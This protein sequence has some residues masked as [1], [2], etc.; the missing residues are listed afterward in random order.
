M[1]RPKPTLYGGQVKLQISLEV[2]LSMSVAMLIVLYLASSFTA[3]YSS[4]GKM[5][6]NESSLACAAINL[7]NRISSECSYCISL[8]RGEC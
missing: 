7:S 6:A 2:L 4:Y 5:H 3:M 1:D 8:V